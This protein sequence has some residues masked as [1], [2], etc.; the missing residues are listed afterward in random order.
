V[1]LKLDENL[2]PRGVELSAFPVRRRLRGQLAAIDVLPGALPQ[3]AF[4]GEL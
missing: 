2:G 1:K 3:R 4:S